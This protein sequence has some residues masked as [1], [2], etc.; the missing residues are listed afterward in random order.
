MSALAFSVLSQHL[1]P[2]SSMEE[3]RS[4]KPVVTGSSPV[5]GSFFHIHSLIGIELGATN[6]GGLGSNPSGC[7]LY[8][9]SSMEEHDVTNFKVLGSSPSGCFFSA[10]IAQW[11]SGGF[12]S[13]WLQVR[14][15]LGVP[16]S[17]QLLYRSSNRRTNEKAVGR[18]SGEGSTI[19]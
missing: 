10:P 13:R 18:R 8:T 7:S 16:F 2:H 3:H 4:S 19:C 15:L 12:R 6:L 17:Q 1:C 11:K 9:H 5:G 14:V